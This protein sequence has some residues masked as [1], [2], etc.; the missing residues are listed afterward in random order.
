MLAAISDTG[1]VPNLLN[2]SCLPRAR[3]LGKTCHYNEGSTLTVFSKYTTGCK[4]VIG[5]DV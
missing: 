2:E 4:N 1:T 3:V 5:L